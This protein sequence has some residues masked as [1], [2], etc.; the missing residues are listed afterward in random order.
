MNDIDFL[1]ESV[2]FQPGRLVEPGSWVGHIPFGS[3]IVAQL[4]PRLLVELG[5]HTGNSYFAFCQSVA[6]QKLAT[7]CCAVDTW[8][9]D[10]QAGFYAEEVYSSVSLQNDKLYKSFSSLLRMTFDEAVVQFEDG[11]IDLL[12]IDGLHTYEAV[13]HDFETWKAKLSNRSVVLFHDISVRNAGFG[14]WKLWEELS[15]EYPHIDFTHSHGLGVLFVGEEQPLFVQSLLRQWLIPSVQESIRLFFKQLGRGIDFELTNNRLI[16]VEND[17]QAL[18]V[19]R[20][21]QIS[22]L[23][24]TVGSRDRRVEELLLAISGLQQQTIEKDQLNSELKTEEAGLKTEVAGLKTEVAGLKTE[25]AGLKNELAESKT[26]LARK[27]KELAAILGSKSWKITR[28]LRLSRQGVD[29]ILHRF[30]RRI[31]L[32]FQGKQRIKCF[33]FRRL[34]SLFS[35]SQAYRIW[36]R[37]NV[38]TSHSHLCESLAATEQFA[39][40]PD[41][42]SVDRYVPLLETKAPTEVPV[43]VIAFYLPQFHPIPENDAWWGV[44]FTEWKNVKP[45]VP[46]FEGHYQPHVPGELG[47]YD[48]L[49]STVQ[50]RQ[51]EL[52]KLY[53][54]G[55]FCF[56]FYWFAGKRLLEQPIEAYLGNQ[57]L[58]LPFCLCWANENWSRRWDGL[59][60]EILIAQQHSPEDDLA[61]IAHV[62]QYMR[63]ERYIR[64][65]GRPLLVVYWPGQLPSPKATANR[66]RQWCR[67]NGLGEIYLAYTQS[68]EAT[69]PEKYGFD[70]AVEFPPNNM[71]PPEITTTVDPLSDDYA[72]IVYDWRHFLKHSQNYQKPNYKL[73]RGCC[74]SWDN[75]ARRKSR[76]TV[77]L[78]SSPQGYQEWLSNAVEDT[79][80]RFANVDER[81]VFVNAWN[82]W[83]EGAHLE[84]DQKNGYAWLDATRKA[85][86][87]TTE[88]DSQR[89]IIVVSHDA[90]PHGAQYLALGMVRSLSQDLGLEV[91]V[92]L[93]GAGRLKGE[94]AALAPIH[95]LSSAVEGSKE[96]ETLARDLSRRGFVRAIVNTVVS[97]WVAPLFRRAGINSTCL[98]HEL[99]GVIRQFDLQSQ[100]TMIAESA[101]TVVFP[102]SIVAEGFAQFAEIEPARQVIRP[103]GLYRRNRWRYKQQAAKLEIQRRHGLPADGQLVLAVGYADQRKGVDLFV[104]TALRILANRSDVDFIWVGHWEE[105]MQ[106]QVELR[107][108]DEP[109]RERLHFVGYDPDTAIYHAASDVYALTSREDPFPNVVLESFDVAVPVVAFAKTGGAAVLVE[110]TGGLVV[111]ELDPD[112]FA[113]AII[114]L[115]DDVALSDKLGTEGQQ[116]V[117]QQYS[118]RTYLFDLCRMLG[119]DL[120]R[121]TVVVPNWNYAQ[122]IEQ[123]LDSIRQQ[124]I[125]FYELILLDDASDDDSRQKM[126][127]WLVDTQTEARLIVNSENSGNV[128]AQWQKGITLARG[129]YLWIAEA[130]DLADPEFL[131]TVLPQ[132]QSKETVLSYCE[133]AQIDE[134]GNVLAP[135]YRSYLEPLAP[136]NWLSAYRA[137]GVDEIRSALAVL[138]TI[139]NVSAVLFDRARLAEVFK[140]N[141][142]EI[143]SFQRAGDWFVYLRIL[144]YG[145]IAFSPKPANQHRRHSGSV[146]AAGSAQALCDEIAAIQKL[147]ASEYELE[148]E[149]KAKANAY[150]LSLHEQFNLNQVPANS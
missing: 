66:W 105:Q 76:G 147:I 110:Q 54:V 34:P 30:W 86:V 1:D 139:P 65:N 50:Q 77:F 134:Q 18:L 36:S 126:E 116:L 57:E 121:V 51:V 96:V 7:K 59:D 145:K 41:V 26:E 84:P 55:G 44:G 5:T 12:H 85:L 6:V 47:Y 144:G 27:N 149:I 20:Q 4:H 46:H 138:N 87:G 112:C 64:I 107:L 16:A 72:G 29:A 74:P 13:R 89:K 111:A 19:D 102:S 22:A 109:L 142:A 95:D 93:L 88:A 17:L 52:A 43:K 136:R 125:P 58:D 2:L 38:S 73:F 98:I 120:P 80:E 124:S 119:L 3:W 78:H 70:A 32:S 25:V 114:R 53:G 127:Q 83:A 81:L 62:A 99:P 37:D 63:D 131:A 79:C 150:L 82:E 91:E 11:S 106:A 141:F 35:W 140:R 49:D 122:Y 60:Q 148:A 33:L 14:V 68:F 146:I 129:D 94:F 40:E 24:L 118:F 75:T 115:L 130:D 23:H 113:E 69:N 31:P 61:F 9:G 100:A 92:V 135:N 137:D 71:G 117:D 103:Q 90:H 48:L 67:D 133:S 45:A 8:Q 123:R 10:E 39:G 21:E 132:L 128:F 42:V 15:A 101:D 108:K 97:G 104:E 143:L 28:P 56:Y